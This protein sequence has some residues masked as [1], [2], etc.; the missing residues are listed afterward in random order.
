[1][2]TPVDMQDRT[3]NVDGNVCT[4]NKN[5]CGLCSI[6]RGIQREEKSNGRKQDFT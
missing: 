5:Y 4:Q 2:S 1:M 6:E 3:Q